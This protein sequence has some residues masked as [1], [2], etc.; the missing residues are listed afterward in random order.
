MTGVESRAITLI[1][2][3]ICR[4]IELGCSLGSDSGGVD[5]YILTGVSKYRGSN[6]A[7]GYSLGS[8]R[9]GVDS[10]ILT[11]VSK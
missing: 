2:V 10:Y 4:Y 3:K 7:E 9:G 6:F 1:I 11:G 8:D 5:S